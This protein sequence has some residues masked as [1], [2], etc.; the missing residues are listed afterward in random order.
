MCVFL[1]LTAW[2]LFS[3]LNPDLQGSPSSGLRQNFKTPV[4]VM[5]SYF[6]KIILK[7]KLKALTM[8]HCKR[9]SVPFLMLFHCHCVCQRAVISSLSHPLF[10]LKKY[11]LSMRK[12]CQFLS[13]FMLYD[14]LHKHQNH[15]GRIIVQNYCT[16]ENTQVNWLADCLLVCK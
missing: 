3:Y 9:P 13:F 8:L 11:H 16:W 7:P 1:W 2:V 6:L 10:H 5:S 15:H 12:I 14:L 4:D